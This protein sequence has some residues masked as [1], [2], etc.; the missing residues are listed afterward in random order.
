MYT[1]TDPG[2]PIGGDPYVISRGLDH[3][4]VIWYLSSRYRDS[5]RGN[6]EAELF[7]DTKLETQQ[8]SFF[9]ILV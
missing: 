8:S 9:I 2:F 6:R 3:V 1:R 4:V 5:N 7:L